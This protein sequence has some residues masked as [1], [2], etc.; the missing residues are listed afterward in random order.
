MHRSY[1]STI[2]DLFTMLD[3][4][5]IA[6]TEDKQA[7]QR[8]IDATQARGY[9]GHLAKAVIAIAGQPIFDHW[10]E[11]NEIDFALADRN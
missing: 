5:N 11:T 6:D 9:F 1:N 4:A 10:C 2:Q 8:S 7:W 3:R